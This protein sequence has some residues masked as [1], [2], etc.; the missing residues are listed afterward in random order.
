MSLTIEEIKDYIIPIW[1]WSSLA[2]LVFASI[3]SLHYSYMELEQMY[4]K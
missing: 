4:Q 2:A 3:L 1:N